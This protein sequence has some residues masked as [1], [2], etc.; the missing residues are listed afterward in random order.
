[1]SI[2]DW[3]PLQSKDAAAKLMVAMGQHLSSPIIPEHLRPR[4]L[5][6]SER[7]ESVGSISSISS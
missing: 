6:P 5:P 1:M 4:G 7:S 2:N 3:M